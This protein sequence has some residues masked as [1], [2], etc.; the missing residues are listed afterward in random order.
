MH[1][2]DE[3]EVTIERVCKIG[4]SSDV[5]PLSI[6]TSVARMIKCMHSETGGRKKLGKA[7]VTTAVLCEAVD[8]QQDRSRGF[9]RGPTLP[10]DLP[11]A[12]GIKSAIAMA[13]DAPSSESPA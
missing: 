6:G 10:V 3:R 2:F 12:R 9:R 8:K 7:L 4:K 5:A 13:H 1:G 11:G